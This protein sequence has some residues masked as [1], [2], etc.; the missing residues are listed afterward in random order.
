MATSSHLVEDTVDWGNDEEEARKLIINDLI[1]IEK[2]STDI[3]E[4]YSAMS[5]SSLD[6]KTKIIKKLKKLGNPLIVPV[7][8]FLL[9]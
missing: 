8:S 1:T 6:R 7:L 5:F 4:N 9:R 2:D 3:D